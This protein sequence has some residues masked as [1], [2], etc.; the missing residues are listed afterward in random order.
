MCMGQVY[1]N[2]ELTKIL[3]ALS[4][5]GAM[6]IRKFSV[7]SQMLVTTLTMHPR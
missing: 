6:K 2:A 1:V 5:I 4:S 7:D 3:I